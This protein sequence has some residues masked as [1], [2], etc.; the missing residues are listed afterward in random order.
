MN[1]ND[2]CQK[3]A[4]SYIRVSTSK[5]HNI[6]NSDETQRLAIKEY[7]NNNNI[8]I[9]KEYFDVASG[10]DLARPQFQKMITELSKVNCILVYDQSRLTRDIKDLVI[11]Q[12]IFSSLEIEV[13]GVKEPINFNSNYGIFISEIKASI[14]KLERKRINDRTKEGIKRFKLEKGY[15]GRKNKIS[16]RSFKYWYS[17]KDIK[18]ISSLAKILGV[19]RTTIYN[20]MKKN[21]IANHKE[22]ELQKN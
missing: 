19:S 10:K 15:W 14:D 5:Q 12:D 13:I 1:T 4:F 6:N 11:L 2:S 9:Q 18:N 3:L 8:L 21:N 16:D 7:C 22:I 17:K 20:Y